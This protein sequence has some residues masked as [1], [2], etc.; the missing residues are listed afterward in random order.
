MAPVPEA[1]K[2]R[3]VLA[4]FG[5]DTGIDD[6]RLLM[7]R[8]D[9]VGDGGFVECDPVEGRIVP[10]CTGPLVL[11][12]VAT[13]IAKSGVSRAHEPEPQQ[14]RN[15]LPLR[16]LALV[17]RWEYP[18]EQSHGVPPFSVALAKTTLE[19]KDPCGYSS[20]KTVRSIDHQRGSLHSAR[21]IDIVHLCILMYGIGRTL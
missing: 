15:T 11:R 4:T 2:A 14:M 21:S 3:G 12:A 8:R 1:I 10:P 16:L 7:L 17:E 13:P 6:Q 5:D 18:V 20:A 19:D 9:D